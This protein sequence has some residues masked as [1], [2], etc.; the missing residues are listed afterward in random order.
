MHTTVRSLTPYLLSIA[1]LHS[2]LSFAHSEIDTGERATFIS[3]TEVELPKNFRSWTH[4][5]TFLNPPGSIT[6]LDGSTVKGGMFANTYVEP[7]AL[8]AFKASGKWPDG[9]QLIK[10]F[11]ESDL[12][13]DCDAASG[14]CK[15]AVG[16]G[17]FQ[18][19]YI[20]AG[21]MVKDAKRFPDAPGNWGYFGFGPVSSGA[22]PQTATLRPQAQCSACHVENRAEQDYV[23]SDAHIGIG[24]YPENFT[25]ELP[26]AGKSK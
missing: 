10:E 1:V 4:V 7:T 16:T 9:T 19:H 20:G 15:T 13:G 3:N 5:G 24:Q 11:T 21:Y 6:I 2:S 12:T 8:A 14:I 23:F 18:H 26:A 22:Y 17:V 25:T